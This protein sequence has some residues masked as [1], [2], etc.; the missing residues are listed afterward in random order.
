MK[1]PE[2]IT[3][4]PIGVVRSEF[5]HP[6]G[7]PRQAVGAKG[8]RGRIEIDPE[9]AE[10]LRDLEGFSHVLVLFHLHLVREHHLTAHP[11]WDDVPHGVFATCSPYRPTPI[12]VSVVRLERREGTT[13]HIRELDMADGSPV[14]DLKP[15][16]P[17]L[18]PRTDV[19]VGWLADKTC[20][21]IR[22]RSGDRGPGKRH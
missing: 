18:F 19:R 21:M 7:I 10:G 13:L 6:R 14:L 20:G 2:S 22:S 12:G 5:E 1:R 11:P 15:Y 3:Y 17:A 9:W 4:R 16:I 8:T